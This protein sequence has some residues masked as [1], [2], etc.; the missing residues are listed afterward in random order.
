M[1]DWADDWQP[2]DEDEVSEAGQ[3][4]EDMLQDLERRRQRS[5]RETTTTSAGNTLVKRPPE[6]DDC[7]S[8]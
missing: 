1:G 7:T 4:E 2:G 8:W 6:L 3:L 5:E